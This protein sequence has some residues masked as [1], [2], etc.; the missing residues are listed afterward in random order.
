MGTFCAYNQLTN[1]FSSAVVVCADVNANA[2]EAFVK[3][4]NK[5]TSAPVA[6]FLQLDVTKRD[7][8]FDAFEQAHSSI[9][10]VDPKAKLDFI[11]PSVLLHRLSRKE[12][13]VIGL[14]VTLVSPLV[15]I[16][17]SRAELTSVDIFTYAL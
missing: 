4:L 14:L 13:I 10:K 6:R 9:T 17:I 1:V 2:G 3:N 7:A 12:L 16:H 15:D 11:F 8:V 5:D